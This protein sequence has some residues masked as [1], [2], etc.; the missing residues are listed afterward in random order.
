MT[1]LAQPH[2]PSFLNRKLVLSVTPA[3]LV[4]LGAGLIF[5]SIPTINPGD[6]QMP[7]TLIRWILLF[8]SG[9]FIPL[10]EMSPPH[11]SF[12]IFSHSLMP[13]I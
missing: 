5:G 13:K 1:T 2:A 11:A 9:V 7:S 3:R 12:P 6:V 10:A 4:L 8:I